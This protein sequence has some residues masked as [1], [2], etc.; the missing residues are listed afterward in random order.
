MS[1]FLGSLTAAQKTIGLVVMLVVL[2]L[3]GGFGASV[4]PT[5]TNQLYMPEQPIPFDH[6]L[7]AGVRKIDCKYCHVG[8][9]NGRHATVP[10]VNICMNCH[11]E[12][13]TDRPAI[14]E[15]TKAYQEGRAIEWVR[16]HELPDFVF[17]NHRPHVAAGVRCQTCHGPVETM[18]EVYQAKP[19]TMGWCLNCHRGNSTPNS[20]LRKFHPDAENAHGMPVAP[21]NCSTCHY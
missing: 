2:V 9:D 21:T 12:V 13:R 4:F 15:L 1:N 17:F 19:L 10:S 6:K 16:V 11:K 7:H 5:A 8:A 20:V 14:Q 18:T 3:V